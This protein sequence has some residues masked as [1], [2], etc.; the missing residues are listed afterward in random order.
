MK[1]PKSKHELGYTDQ[2]VRSIL[3]K[4][5]IPYKLYWEKFG[6]NTCG[7]SETGES[8]F[9]HCDVRLAIRCCI[10]KRDKHFYEWD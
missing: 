1:F 6:I 10:E 7:V 2:E 8:L 4:L 3:K 9:Y 5:E